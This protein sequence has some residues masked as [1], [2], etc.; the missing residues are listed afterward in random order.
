M[1]VKKQ[2]TSMS[3]P[4]VAGSVALLL[5]KDPT[6]TASEI[7]DL[8]TETADTDGFTGSTPNPEWGYGRLDVLEA[9]TKLVNS[10]GSATHTVNSNDL[11]PD[12]SYERS[13]VVG[14]N[15]DDAQAVRFTPS[16][17][18]RLSG[19]Y[20]HLDYPPANDLTG[21]LL[22]GVYA[23][24]GGVPGSQIGSTVEVPASRL[25]PGTWNFQNLLGT[26]VQLSTGQD[27][28]L[29][30]A[31][32]YSGD[33]L[34]LM[35]ED[36]DGSGNTLY[37]SSGTWSEASNADALVRP[38]TSGLSGVKSFTESI[39]PFAISASTNGTS[40]VNLSWSAAKSSGVSE[41]RIYRQTSPINVD[42][43]SLTPLA[44]T[45]GS[46]T[47]YTDGSVTA[48]KTYYY[49]LTGVDG[50]GTESGFSGEENAFLYPETVS[51]QA[52]RSF[53]S[54]SSPSDY[55][56]VALPGAVDQS[57]SGAVSGTAG[58]DWQAYRE[59]SSGLDRFDGSGAFSFTPGTGF[60]LTA[61]DAWSFEKDLSTVSLQ[62]GEAATIPVRQGWNIISNPLGKDVSWAA[63]EAA[64]PGA[65]QPLW[66]FG[67][68]FAE[69]STFQSAESGVAYYFF[70]GDADR[71]SL[72][73]PY[74]TAPVKE[75]LATKQAARSLAARSLD[76][77]SSKDAKRSQETKKAS[78]SKTG[79]SLVRVQAREARGDASSS[80]RVGALSQNPSSKEASPTS[81]PSK[82]RSPKSSSAENVSS[83]AT[84]I[85][86]PPGRF[87]PLSLRVEPP[88]GEKVPGRTSTLMQDRRSPKQGGVTFP[89]RLQSRL[90]G[91]V[92]VTAENLEAAGTEAAALVRPATGDTYD[93]KRAESI[94]ITLGG[95]AGT[96]NKSRSETDARRTETLKVVLGSEEYVEAEKAAAR[97]DEVALSAY[98]NPVSGQGTIEYVLPEAGSVRL[99]M[100]DLLGRRVRTVVSGQKEAG[101][102][103]I[104]FDAGR[105]SSG[106][107]FGRLRAGGETKTQKIVVVR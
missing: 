55:R 23:D 102:H 46:K 87:E 37:Y 74:P 25:R 100:Y 16:E 4:V 105:L 10:S 83:G 104:T 24:N 81:R 49:R 82:S 30:Y 103:R 48:G 65:L 35:W 85:V 3:A 7:K 31:P 94:K 80:V 44:T 90:E 50:T 97:P 73:V 88:A 96:D 61:T 64:T 70:N 95:D 40:E 20:F 71:S 33:E 43:S 58:T 66:G 75:P 9:M 17:D 84:S 12:G 45:S 27:Y 42:P 26:D 41:Y 39:T 13:F 18:G 53:G 32:K 6:L 34:T 57:L 21:P 106:V 60:W 76:A 93:L 36:Y 5:E 22:V 59:S 38:V 47:S 51:A 14:G 92:Q 98:P 72:T 69:E 101:R 99:T 56:L 89:L 62:E 2:G 68:G 1:H 67:G 91:P 15:G 29:V 78:D 107:Y 8:L 28:Y 86:A 11:H 19:A 54:A 79:S 52:S 63:V 77:E